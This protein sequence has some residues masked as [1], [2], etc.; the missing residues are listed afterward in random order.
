MERENIVFPWQ[1][2]T[3]VPMTNRK[4]RSHFAPP[5]VGASRENLA[6][7]CTEFLEMKSF[8]PSP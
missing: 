6:A 7:L 8:A 1:F 3:A 4:E 5:Y 2:R